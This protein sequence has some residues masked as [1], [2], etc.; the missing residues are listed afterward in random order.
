M[1][2]VIARILSVLI[3][4]LLGLALR[5]GRVF[6]D[7]EGDVLRA[8]VVRFAVPVMIF[9]SMYEAGRDDISAMPS[10]V[11]GLVVLTAALFPLGLLCSRLVSGTGRKSAVHACC[12]LGNYGW[13]GFGVAQVLLGE[14][15]LR[16]AVFFCVLWWPVF[17]GFGLPV[18]LIHAR[19]ERAGVPIRKTLKLVLPIISCLVAGLVFNLQGWRLPPLIETTLKPFGAMTVPLILFSVGVML[20]LSGVRKALAPALLVSAFTLVVA[21]LVGWAVAAILTRDPIS[22]AVVILNGAMPVAM[23]TPILAE[24]F[25]MDL[26]V[27]NTSI[28]VST[29][30]SLL[31]LPVVAYL[32]VP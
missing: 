7:R 15:G 19:R 2:D 26:D 31:T 6:G 23:L 16:R 10:M 30:L 11:A 22:Y 9:F 27:A 21:P 1:N 8:F 3:P 14:P 5:L 4:I 12:V 13:L 17:Y 25:E 18:G 29:L 20:D 28:V 32:V 24:N